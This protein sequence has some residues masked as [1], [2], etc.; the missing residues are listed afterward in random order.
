MKKIIITAGTLIL[1][2]VA[3]LIGVLLY[4]SQKSANKSRQLIIYFTLSGNTKKAAEAL[5]QDT[6]ADI[7]RLRPKKAYP[8]TYDAAVKVAKK[9]LATKTHPAIATAILN[10]EQYKTIYVGLVD[11]K[12]NPN[13][14]RTKKISFL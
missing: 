7:I 3:I 8:T 13:A 2:G 9:E 4:G 11:C 6:D 14:V 10:L 12:I 5:Q 1:V